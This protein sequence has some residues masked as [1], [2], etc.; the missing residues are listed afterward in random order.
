MEYTND[1]IEI[2]NYIDPSKLSY[3]E[4]CCVG[5]A[6]KHEGYSPQEWDLWSQKDSKRYHRNECYKKWNS[7]TG[8]GV[9]GGTIVQ[10]AI[11]L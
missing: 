8:K 5:M 1:L 11:V 7:F 6:L 4:W 10:F 9:S 2:L 3:Q